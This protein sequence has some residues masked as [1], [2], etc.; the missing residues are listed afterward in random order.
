MKQLKYY[1]FCIRWLWRNREWSNTRQK[2][3]ALERD[4]IKEAP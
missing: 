4:W 2:F 3:R 1:I